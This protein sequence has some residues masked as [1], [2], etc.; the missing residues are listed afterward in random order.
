MTVANARD[1]ANTSAATPSGV[2][3]VIPTI[4]RAEVLVDTVKDL[5]AQ[6]FDRYEIIVVDQS[7]EINQTVVELLRESPVPARYFKADNFRGLPQA[8]N[9]GWQQARHDIVLYIDDDIRTTRTF[10][11]TH[12][13]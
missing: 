11:S 9:F 3:V 8:R 6:D 13:D 12:Y 4:N 10:V 5:L 1:G 7:D 2:S